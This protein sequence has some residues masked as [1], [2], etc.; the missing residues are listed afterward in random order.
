[1]VQTVLS[2]FGS[3]DFA[4]YGTVTPLEF[5]AVRVS[6]TA[7]VTWMPAMAICARLRQ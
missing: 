5:G 1:M 3:T 6:Y 2:A 7:A 4:R